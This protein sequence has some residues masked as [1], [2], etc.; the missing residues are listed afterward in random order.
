MAPALAKLCEMLGIR[1]LRSTV[2]HP[3]G[4]APVERFHQDL[5]RAFQD[6]HLSAPSCDDLP[7]LLAFALM[8]Y[9]M[10]PHATTGESPA[11]M[12]HGLNPVL[13]NTDIDHQDL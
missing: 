11:F 8:K 2:Y 7:E 5:K 4:N 6:L 1:Q 10:T 3:Q 9:R 13:R 12:M